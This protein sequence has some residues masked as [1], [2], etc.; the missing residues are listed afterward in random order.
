[1]ETSFAKSIG[2]EDF[3]SRTAVVAGVALI[4]EVA[5]AQQDKTDWYKSLVKPKWMPNISV[6]IILSIVM[7]VIYI[8]CW[9]RALQVVTVNLRLQVDLIFSAG[10]LIKLLWVLNFFTIRNISFSNGLIFLSVIFIVFQI[11]YMWRILKLGDCALLLEVYL[12]W[13]SVVAVANF[14]IVDNTPCPKRGY[15]VDRMQLRSNRPKASI[16][17]SEQS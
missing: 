9:Y 2:S 11:W 5:I 12:V 17:P 8:W 15:E 13:T 14:Q 10:L 4:S 3:V 7:Y 16:D 6:M 1:M